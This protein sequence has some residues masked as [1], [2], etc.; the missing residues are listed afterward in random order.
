MSNSKEITIP[1]IGDFNEVDVIEVLVAPG[2]L[3][4]LDDPLITLESDKASM[5]IPAPEAGVVKALKVAVGDKVSEGSVILTLDTT[6]GAEA[7][8]AHDPQ[9]R[10]HRTGSSAPA[11]GEGGAALE[12]V[13]VP[14]IGDFADVDVIEVL[15]AEGDSIGVDDPLITPERVWSALLL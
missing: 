2:D 3:I 4:A 15:V 12:D 11:P 8:A 5:D 14:E 13:H 6:A 10:V 9:P 1:D 7:S